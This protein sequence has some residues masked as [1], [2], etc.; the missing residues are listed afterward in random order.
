MR[1]IFH[2]HRSSFFIR[3]RNCTRFI[4][5]N[6]HVMPRFHLAIDDLSHQRLAQ[7]DTVHLLLDYLLMSI[8]QENTVR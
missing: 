1:N 7:E 2:R 5:T 3:T 6:L 8:I 4:P